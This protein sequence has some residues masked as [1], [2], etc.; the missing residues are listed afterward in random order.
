MAKRSGS[1][2]ELD[3]LNKICAKASNKYEYYRSNICSML[4]LFVPI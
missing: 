3:E 1:H 2:R 4:F